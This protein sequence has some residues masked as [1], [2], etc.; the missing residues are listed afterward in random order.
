M[1]PLKC[2]EFELVKSACGMCL[3]ADRAGQKK[4]SSNH[5]VIGAVFPF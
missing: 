4:N 5:K 3:M 2:L 1:K